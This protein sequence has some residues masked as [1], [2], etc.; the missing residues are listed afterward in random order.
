MAQE[1]VGSPFNRRPVLVR[2]VKY[3]VDL[4][5]PSLELFG[6][7]AYF[8]VSSPRGERRHRRVYGEGPDQTVVVLFALPF[9]ARHSSQQRELFSSHRSGLDWLAGPNR[10]VVRYAEHRP[11]LGR[12]IP[13]PILPD[14]V[15]PPDEP[16]RYVDDPQGTFAPRLLDI[17]FGPPS[18]G[19]LGVDSQY[20][21]GGC[22]G[23]PRFVTQ[24]FSHRVFFICNRM[25]RTQPPE[26]ASRRAEACEPR[27]PQARGRTG[28]GLAALTPPTCPSGT[29]TLRGSG[30]LG[31]GGGRGVRARP[32]HPRRW[33]RGLEPRHGPPF[34]RRLR[35]R[36]P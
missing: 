16:F 28:M 2:W 33:R 21:E 36:G 10:S 25:E 7:P 8:Q 19:H 23:I 17:L 31:R 32:R 20:V 5:R 35:R 30:S 27:R 24:S 14:D 12:R 34:L 6:V 29:R 3:L 9:H 11:P 1:V 4:Q 26:R 13:G 22:Q 15:Y 18:F